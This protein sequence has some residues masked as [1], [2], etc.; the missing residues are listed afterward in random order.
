VE[1]ICCYRILLQNEG[2]LTHQNSYS[3]LNDLSSLA[4][5]CQFA[6]GVFVISAFGL[7]VQFEWHF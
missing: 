7:I 5:E 1:E 2:I 6:C 4:C 3:C